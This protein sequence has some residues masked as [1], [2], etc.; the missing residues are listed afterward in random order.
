[1]CIR[2]ST[3]SRLRSGLAST[4][5]TSTGARLHVEADRHHEVA[6]VFVVDRL[7]QARAQWRDQPQQHLLAAYG[8][9]AVAEELRVEA[10]LQ[11]LALERRRHRLLGVADIGRRRRDLQLARR[12]REALE[13]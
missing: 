9:D 4:A 12:K 13:I 7:Q 8:L 1:M 3:P 2:D 5:A 10:D 11:R 6:E